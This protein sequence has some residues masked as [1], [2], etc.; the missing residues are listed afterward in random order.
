MSKGSKRRRR[1]SAAVAQKPRAVSGK[2]EIWQQRLQDSDQ[3][4]AGEREKMDRREALF[5]GDDELK[6]LVPGDSKRDGSRKRTSHVRNI[7]F[8]NIESQISS[9]IPQPKVTPRRKKDEHLAE[10][11]EHFIRNELDRQ[12]FEIMN[13]MA[14]RTVPIQGGVAFMVEWD[15]T[16][17][18]QTTV[19]EADVSVI[20]PKQ[21][22]PQPGIYTSI[23]DMDWII[24]KVPTTK[25]A[26]RRQYGKS[27]SDE[28]E[29]E[30]QIR[31]T[32]EEHTAQDAVTMYVGYQKGECGVDKYVWVNDVELEDLEDYQAR[33]QP[34]CS[35]CGRVR[36]LPGQVIYNDVPQEPAMVAGGPDMEQMIAGRRMAQM[37][38]DQVMLGSGQEQLLPGVELDAQPEVEYDGGPC[39]WCGCEDFRDQAQEQE[40]VM[41]PVRTDSGVKIPGATAGIGKDGMPVLR[42]TMIPF[43]KPDV[44]PIVLQRS[45][46]RYGQLLGSSDVDAIED[47]QNTINR[48][49]QKIIDRLVKAGTRV[50]L[51][52]RADFRIDPEDGEKWYPGNAAEKNLIDVY[53][54]SGDLQ[55]ELAYL[56][57]VYEEAR[58]ILGIT[59]S[60]Q[61]R[62]DPTATSGVA[63]EYSAAQAAGRLESKRV[64]KDAAYAQLFELM[65]KFWLA[66]SDE[67]RPISYKD[68]NGDTQY[69]EFN[70]YDFLEQDADGQWY[71][72]DQFLFSCDTSAPLASNREAMWQETRMNLQT[73]AFG[74]PART[75]TLILFWGKMEDLHYPGAATTKKYLEDRLEQERAQMQQ[76]QMMQMAQAQTGGAAPM[77]TAP[78]RMT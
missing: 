55:Y 11:I 42:P 22:A 75:E 34:V 76:M 65:F 24:V 32:G 38:A 5:D 1:R 12:P 71:W 51:P 41:I 15:N 4:W 8:E 9:T 50:T 45:V 66:Y 46:S 78:K 52:D 19:G 23:D 44:Y 54:F 60:F 13:D 39:P 36:P 63:K 48:L 74:D 26:V 67:P 61:G 25:E 20:H 21:L 3:Y 10:L 17:R 56:A 16:K 33:R 7:I 40:Q 72:N 2:L 49:E 59:D 77:P 29:S 35:H 70:R 69:Q 18:T 28:A 62:R 68:Q 73:G 57:Q 30:P 6:P 47:Q 31:G 64:M 53:Q 43:Y 14:E 27:V 58:Q 37:L